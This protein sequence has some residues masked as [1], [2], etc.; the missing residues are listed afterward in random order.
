MPRV[1]NAVLLEKIEN[2]KGYLI[3][4]NNNQDE[5]ITLQE[6]KTEKNTISIAGIKAASGVIAG[7]VSLIIAGIAVYFGGKQ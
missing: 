2:L 6:K 3:E 1:T 4:R 7:V 5:R